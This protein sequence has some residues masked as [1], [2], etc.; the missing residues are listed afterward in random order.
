[1]ETIK[2]LT[3]SERILESLSDRQR[4]IFILYGEGKSP[5]EIGKILF[6]SK[7]TVWSHKQYTQQAMKISSHQYMYF[8]IKYHVIENEKNI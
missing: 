4:E 5:E 6:I 1:M 8:A 2:H 3:Y 7:K